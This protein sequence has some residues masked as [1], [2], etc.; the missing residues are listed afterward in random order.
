MDAFVPPLAIARIAS[1]FNVPS[2]PE[3]KIGPFVVRFDILTVCPDL[4][5]RTEVAFVV[6]TFTIEVPPTLSKVRFV[7][8]PEL[9]VNKPVPRIEVF[10]PVP[11]CIAVFEVDPP[12]AFPI[13]IPVNVIPAPI[14]LPTAISIPFCVP[15]VVISPVVIAKPV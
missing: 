15:A 11:I 4:P 1:E 8:D 12:L 6:P 9:I 10:H 3:V 5:I 2:A 14:P 13:L 7:P